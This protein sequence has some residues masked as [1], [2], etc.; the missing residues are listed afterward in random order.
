MD[1]SSRLEAKQSV[2]I[3]AKLLG[4]MKLGQFFSLPEEEFSRYIE[5][6]EKD[7]LFQLLLKEYRIVSYRKFKDVAGPRGLSLQ[8]EL[9]AGGDFDL[10]DLSQEDPRGWAL[11][12]KVALQLGE[13]TFSRF[14]LGE[15]LS[16]KEI[17][18][19]CQLSQ[20]DSA[21]FLDFINRFQLRRSFVQ[22]SS[23]PS[24][25]ARRVARIEKQE[26][27]LVILPIEYSEYLS[28]G[29]YLIN[30]DKWERVLE[31]HKLPS[32]RID[33]I[34][35]L[36][37]RLDLINRRSTTLHQV[38]Y[39]LKEVQRAFLISARAEDLVPL[40][41]KDM[42]QRIEVH[43]SS[44]S[45]TIAN[46]S[47][48]TPQGKEMFIKSFFGRKNISALILKI[49]E[50]ERKKGAEG[51]LVK[52]FSDEMIRKKLEQR[53]GVKIARRTVNKYRKKCGTRSSFKRRLHSL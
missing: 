29:K 28:R 25:K 36:F 24:L 15:G 9:V 19:K 32:E 49:I 33:G 52:P 41:Q 44:I 27:K 47:I 21:T 35:H 14:L 8:E 51:T 50:E 17:E 6:V 26:D 4:R 39:H 37:H 7:P 31:M 40:A 48:I 13:E 42:A 46:K 2:A 18:R 23:A 1:I 3:Q 43:P 34:S 11:V 22:P 45:R 5:E 53:Y 30:Y 12:Q 20:E 16:I 10:E 38:L